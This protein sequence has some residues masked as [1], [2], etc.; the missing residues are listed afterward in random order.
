MLVENEFSLN[1]CENNLLP[2]QL[3]NPLGR[4]VIGK[5]T[6]LFL[7]INYVHIRHGALRVWE[8]GTDQKRRLASRGGFH[9]F[10]EIEELG[11]GGENQ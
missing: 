1:L 11:L 3:S 10:Q 5:E 8:E 6:E 9:F 2:I 4:P 7:N